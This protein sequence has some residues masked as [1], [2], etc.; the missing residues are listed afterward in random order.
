MKYLNRPTLRASQFYLN[1]VIIE[2]LCACQYSLLIFVTV[3]VN[4]LPQNLVENLVEMKKYK[5]LEIGIADNN[6]SEENWKNV[7][8]NETITKLSVNFNIYSIIF[9]KIN[10]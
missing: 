3:H 9:S 4:N 5:N 10:L 1:N 7:S 8:Y 2:S 6:K